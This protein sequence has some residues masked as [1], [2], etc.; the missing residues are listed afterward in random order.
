MT[1]VKV[2]LLEYLI[3]MQR[4]LD[5]CSSIVVE[6]L[7][8]SGEL[9][10]KVRGWIAKDVL[11]GRAH[12]VEVRRRLDHEAPHDIGGLVGEIAEPGLALGQLELGVTTSAHVTADGEHL[13]AICADQVPISPLQPLPG[14][15]VDGARDGVDQNRVVGTEER[16][17][18]VQTLHLVVGEELLEWTAE[19]LGRLDVVLSGPRR[20]AVH[21]R[22]V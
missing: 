9:F 5:C 15:V 3:G 12:V 21:D 11:D 7:E 14:S 8:N 2:E 19:C 20:I 13:G 6:D 1:Q 16:E 17:L 22:E 18:R 10:E 4:T